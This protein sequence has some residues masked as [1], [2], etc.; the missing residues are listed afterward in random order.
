[1]L[2]ISRLWGRIGITAL[3]I[4]TVLVGGPSSR[5]GVTAEEVERAIHDGVRFLKQQQRGDGSWPDVEGNSRSGTTSLVTLA[6]LTAG[7]KADSPAVVNALEFLRKLGP[8]ELRTTYA[9]GL[10]TMVFAAAEPQRD[11][12]RIAANVDWLERAQIRPG[13]PMPWPG[14]WTYTDSKRGGH[15]DN[16]NTQYALLG[17][18][19]ASEAGVPVKPEVWTLSRAYWARFQRNDGSWAYTPD[20]PASSASMTCAGIASLIITGQRRFQDQEFLQG[21]AIQNCGK[22]A[23]NRSLQF[24][25]DWMAR[26]FQVGQ[27]YGMGQQ[28]KYYYLYGL[29]RAGRLAGIRFFGPHDWY[30]LGAEELVQQQNMLA[31]F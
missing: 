4:V 27:N 23:V 14:S 7:E 17:L 16:S 11:Q 28:W 19:A 8:N 24:A 1:M 18:H 6:L 26:N 9:I 30:R 2:H 25:V 15:C 13:D 12:L 22:G 10:Q 29:E 20:V 5:G 21:D 3:V 31:G